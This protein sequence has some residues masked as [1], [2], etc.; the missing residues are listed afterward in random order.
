MSTHKRYIQELKPVTFITFDNNSIWDANSRYLIYENT[1]PDESNNGDPITGIFHYDNHP[2]KVIRP[3]YYFGQTSLI[4]NQKTNSYSIVIAP[5]GYDALNQ[6][7]F[8]KSFIEIPYTDALI[9]DKSFTYTMM[10]NV[11][12]SPSDMRNYIWNTG[13]DTYVSAN[14]NNGYNYSSLKRSIIKKGNK[15]SIT[16]C[17]PYGNQ[18]YLEILFPNNSGNVNTSSIEGGILNKPINLVCSHKY[19]VMDDG[20]Y[21]T[22]SRVYIN[23]R[24]IYSHDSTPLYGKYEGG[25]T[26]PIFLCGNQDVYDN[27]SLNDRWTSPIYIDQF[28]VFDYAVDEYQVGMIYKKIESYE[29]MILYAY[30]SHYYKFDENDSALFF[31]NIVNNQSYYRLYPP[32]Q[33]FQIGYSKA[34]VHGIYGDTCVHIQN[35]GMIYCDEPNYGFFNPSGDYTIEFFASF[36]SSERG[37]LLSIQ[38][39][40]QPFRGICLYVNSKNNEHLS[41]MIQLSI[42][43][44]MYVHTDEFNVRGERVMYNDGKVR[45]YAIRRSGSYVELWIDGVYINKIFFSAGNLTARSNS[46][47]LF[48]MSPSVMRVE[49]TI[50]HLAFYTRALSAIELYTRSSYL[51]RYKMSG[52]VTVNGIGTKVMLRIYS[53]LDGN[54]LMESDTDGDGKYNIDVYNSDYI[55]FIAMIREDTTVRPRIVGPI[56]ADEFEDV[57]WE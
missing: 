6:F 55:N 50:Q 42:T 13:Q 54:L 10:F 14:G 48:N 47:F 22:E 24:L 19:I 30:P 29:D 1:L 17:A 32:T 43:D 3:S 52:R 2:V 56:L 28:A 49:G 44:S 39:S 12:R 37:V 35:S 23:M 7:R 46:L 8:V 41:G 45:H 40:V 38:D 20:R 36:T 21:Y 5:H 4:S 11:P 25:N 9:L 34:G 26:S 18:D 31:P 15:F 57:P 51:I 53:F 27:N 16:Y 33:G